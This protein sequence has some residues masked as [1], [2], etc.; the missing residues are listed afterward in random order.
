[1]P[2]GDQ[3]TMAINTFIFVINGS[4]SSGKDTFVDIAS[5][6]SSELNIDEVV[7][8]SS[9]DVIKKMAKRYGWDENKDEKGRK[10]LADLKEAWDNYNSL[11]QIDIFTRTKRWIISKNS[12]LKP[13]FLFVDIREPTKI[14]TYIDSIEKYYGDCVCTGTILIKQT[15]TEAASNPADQGVN[16]FKY[17]IIIDNDGTIDELKDK[18]R[19]F[20]ES[21]INM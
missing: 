14:K 6:L 12:F 16:N 10:L 4:N 15:R 9:V 3:Y 7:H 21:L 17:D 18:C 20:L 11:T 1:M 13:R 2:K 5:S 19:S 8:I